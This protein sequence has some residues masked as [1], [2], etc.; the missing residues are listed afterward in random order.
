MRV[1]EIQQELRQ[2]QI[3]TQD[4]FEKEELVQRLLTARQQQE[5]STT[6][7]TTTVLDDSKSAS[8]S[9]SNRD[10][11]I[12][13]PL[14]FTSMDKG[15]RVA[16]VNGGGISV[17]TSEQPY[18]TLQIQVRQQQQG[19]SDKEFTLSLLLDTACTGF[20]LRPQVQ[21]KYNLPSYTTPVT[22]T[23]AGGV[24]QATGLT[25]I[26]RFSV[27]GTTTF[28]PTPAVIQDIGALPSSLDGILGL[29]FLSQFA[30]FELDF[31]QGVVSLYQDSNAIPVRQTMIANANMRMLG[32]L[33]IFT[34]DVYI[35][36]R[37]PVS[38]LV[39]T[40][41]ACTLLNWKGVADLGLDRT[42]K[43]LTQI[44]TNVGA[45]GSDNVAIRLTHRLFVSSILCLGDFN[46]QQGISF[47][48]KRLMIDVG[49]IPV[50]DNLPGVGGIL[51]IDVLMR[52]GTVRLSCR[53]PTQISL[54]N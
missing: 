52:C 21:T 25:Q 18:A 16:A 32:S 26:Q 40:G 13:T 7:T 22:M 1:K 44:R 23:G 12:Q 47:A 6:S 14:Y 45:M 24:S 29:A 50:I 11:V 36:R 38:M 33:G 10:G 37:G 53:E 19:S 41:A 54:F 34:V 8:N 48:G 30:A 43:Q 46:N 3:S 42:S 9:V 28:G 49:Q 5:G 4:V 35:G 20:V 17:E 39:D 31:S 15:L 2:R 51:G 27:G